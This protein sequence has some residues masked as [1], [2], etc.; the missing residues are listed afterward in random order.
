MRS[1]RWLVKYFQL[2]FRSK[3][4]VVEVEVEVEVPNLVNLAWRWSLTTGELRQRIIEL[5]LCRR[6][7]I[8]SI[9][10]CAG[11]R[12]QQTN[13]IHSFHESWTMTLQ[14]VNTQKP[15]YCAVLPAPMQGSSMNI[16]HWMGSRFIWRISGGLILGTN[17]LRLIGFLE[18]DNKVM[19]VI[20]DWNVALDRLGSGK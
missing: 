5:R 8:L 11:P 4:V 14:H 3:W 13:R 17:Q 15:K 18:N 6:P 10:Y 2:N 1:W 12:I 19:F 7:Q 9:N 16:G 20:E